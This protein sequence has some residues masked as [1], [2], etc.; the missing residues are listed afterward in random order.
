MPLQFESHSIP[1]I[2]TNDVYVLSDDINKISSRIQKSNRR[3]TKRMIAIE[4]REKR[5][6]QKPSI[7]Y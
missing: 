1:S 2:L 6:W 3:L 5:T 4:R 7:R